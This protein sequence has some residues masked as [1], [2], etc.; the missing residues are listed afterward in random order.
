LFVIILIINMIN[1]RL[2]KPDYIR[3]KDNLYLGDGFIA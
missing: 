2:M 3:L 1:C